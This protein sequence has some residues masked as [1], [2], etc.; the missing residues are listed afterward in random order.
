MTHFLNYNDVINI[1][2][3]NKNGT[4]VLK[5]SIFSICLAEYCEFGFWNLSP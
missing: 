1:R 5:N 2:K 4:I 3:G